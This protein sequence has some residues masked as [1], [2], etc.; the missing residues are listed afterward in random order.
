MRRLQFT[1]TRAALNQIYLSYV[2]PILE[3][4]S[5]VCDGCSVMC[6]ESLEKLQNEAARIVTGLT[7]SASLEN[8]YKECGWETSSSRRKNAKLCFMYKVS[9]NLVP[10]YIDELIPPMV[11]N[12]SQYQLRNSQNYENVQARTR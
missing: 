3:Y 5:I 6:S 11:G 9:N 4:S 7:R 12:R 2:R 10:Q 1:L 8:L